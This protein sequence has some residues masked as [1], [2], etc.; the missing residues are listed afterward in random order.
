MSESISVEIEQGWKLF[1]EGKIEE[2]LSLVNI[3]A[4]REDFTDDVK[5]TLK[6]LEGYCLNTMGNFT[7]SLRIG[8]LAYQEGIR[9]KK[10]LLSIDA[11]VINFW[12]LFFL[13]RRFEIPEEISKCEIMLKSSKNEPQ[14]EIE[15]REASVDFMKGYYLFWK[16]EYDQ[17]LE[18]IEKSLIGFKTSDRLISF[19]NVV[20]NLKGSAYLFKGELGK[21]VKFLKESIEFSKG[22]SLGVN[23]LTGSNLM[24]ISDC[25]YLQGNMDLAEQYIKKGLE[26]FKIAEASGLGYTKNAIVSCYYQMI[27]IYQ[28]KESPEQTTESLNKML[29]YIEDNNVTDA[30]YK[31][32]KAQILISSTR[33]RDWAKAEKV[34]KKLMEQPTWELSLI[35]LS[36]GKEFIPAVTSLCELYL[37]ELETTKDLNILDDIQPLITKLF[38][39]SERRKS[40]SLQAHT[41]L[42]QGK[43]SLLQMN[44]GDARRYLTKAQRIAQNHSLQL[45]AHSI[46]RE[47]DKLFEYLTKIENTGK[48]DIS[49]SE[50]IDMASLSNIIDRMQGRSVFDPPEIIE[51]K[52]LLLLIIG[53]DG[54]SYFNHPFIKNW[55]FD[56]LFSSFM[57]AFNNFSSEIFSE[58]IDRIKIGENLILIKLVETFLVCY[59][60]KGQSYPALQKLNRF[61]D[62]IK[63]K[64]DIWDALNKAIQTSEVLDLNNPTSLGDIV[65]EIFKN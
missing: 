29:Q 25:Y 1:N 55:N 61:S 58:S 7:E 23:I 30:Y 51:E 20:Y 56:D 32:A 19:L 18:Y 10:P 46:S 65:N 54:V 22:N 13:G 42:L 39:E 59:V 31:L 48:S 62:A 9:L 15:Q 43:I 33:A 41:N 35:Q 21:A 8:E 34:L 47:H 64:S 52:P 4:N 6:I 50:R 16:D 24:G 45:L 63:W 44:I 49:F 14:S 11:C 27:R 28:V 12:S 2:T 57:S 53:E 17:S 40:Y 37:K 5:L 26:V 36:L 38:K 3:L 60:M